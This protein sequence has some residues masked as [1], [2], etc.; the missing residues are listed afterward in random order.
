MKGLHVIHCIDAGNAALRHLVGH[1]AM[2]V[3]KKIILPSDDPDEIVADDRL[4]SA[5][6]KLAYCEVM[7]ADSGLKSAKKK[8]KRLHIVLTN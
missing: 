4:T 3:L 5:Q 2:K 7:M 6:E 8:R 1:R